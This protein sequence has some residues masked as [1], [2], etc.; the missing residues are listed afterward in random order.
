MFRATPR[1]ERKRIHCLHLYG[2][3]ENGVGRIFG[4]DRG[5]CQAADGG[6]KARLGE[7]LPNESKCKPE[8]DRGA[9][10]LTADLPAWPRENPRTLFHGKTENERPHDGT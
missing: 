1:S 4:K 5:F 7:H 6:N 8:H 9:G 2:R 3:S 10:G